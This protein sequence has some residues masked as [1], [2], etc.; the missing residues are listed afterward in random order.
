MFAQAPS[1]GRAVP[2]PL[3]LPE[4][5][6][7]SEVQKLRDAPK[8]VRTETALLCGRVEC[9]VGAFSAPLQ[10]HSWECVYWLNQTR[11]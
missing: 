3:D 4:E 10:C 7:I 6:M 9:A 5:Y 8:F 1:N 2:C 11:E